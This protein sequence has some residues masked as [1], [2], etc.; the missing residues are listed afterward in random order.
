ME[1]KY[2]HGKLKGYWTKAMALEEAKKFKV[3]KEWK[4]KNQ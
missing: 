3:Q 1:K 4:K 2:A